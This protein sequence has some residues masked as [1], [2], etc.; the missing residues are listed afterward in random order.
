MS[1]LNNLK[2]TCSCVEGHRE[3]NNSVVPATT[4]VH[5]ELNEWLETV[6]TLNI[7]LLLE[8]ETGTGKDTFAR[9]VYE[10][11]ACDGNFVAI[12]C[13]AI[14][15]T[16]AESELFG[17]MAGA[18]TGAT[19][20]RAGYIESANNGILFLDEID[21]MSLTL[22]AKL[23]RVLETRSVGRLGSTRTQPVNLRIIVASQQPLAE[24][25]EQRLFRQDLYFRL[26]T[27]KI[28][29][30][31][32]RD[33]IEHIVPHFRRFAAE[34]ARRLN[35]P[36][37]PISQSLLEALL[38]H[39]WPGNMRELKG[40]AERFVLGLPPLGQPL[41]C[42]QRVDLRERMR[43]IE[44]CLITDCLSRHENR[45]L[46]A[47]RE[48]GIPSRTLYNRLKTMNNK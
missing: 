7:D 39:R 2:I 3:K 8:G 41:H 30:P 22:Q 28:T 34:A 32:L 5:D 9:K 15:E 4:N 19:Q 40:A 21:S 24:L 31:A 17:V 45:V 36:Y 46:Q 37:P 16:L 33:R 10:R 1:S 27:V 26:A 42:H 43:R 47:A 44:N 6:A 48:L 18:Y 35:R 14:P 20:S 12:N 25:V 29:L 38:M 11:S 23:L 13:A